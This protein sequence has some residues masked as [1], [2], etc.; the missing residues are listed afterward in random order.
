KHS[1][2]RGRFGGINK[3]ITRAILPHKLGRVLPHQPRFL[4]TH[5]VGFRVLRKISRKFG[6]HLITAFCPCATRDGIVHESVL[7]RLSVIRPVIRYRATGMNGAL[8]L[9]YLSDRAR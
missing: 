5:A 4:W 9:A 1:L 8:R 6:D 2:L 3:Q 7:Y